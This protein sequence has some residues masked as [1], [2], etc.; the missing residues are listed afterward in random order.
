MMTISWW[1]VHSHLAVAVFIDLVIAAADA[2]TMLA[3]IPQV[4]SVNG[5]EP[6]LLGLF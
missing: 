1:K 5:D 2:Q 6:V 3:V 4:I